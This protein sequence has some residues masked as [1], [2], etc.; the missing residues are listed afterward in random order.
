MTAV[1]SARRGAQQVRTDRRDRARELDE[2]RALLRR[3]DQR[4]VGEPPSLHQMARKRDAV[5]R[6]L[7]RR[8]S[9]V[10]AGEEES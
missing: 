4:P 5:Q 2:I 6:V 10:A 3:S 7:E 1:T 8:A 9:A